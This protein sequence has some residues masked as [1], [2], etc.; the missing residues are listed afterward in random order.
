MPS[1]QS[2]PHHVL[3]EAY[4]R[5]V[6]LSSVLLELFASCYVSVYCGLI[7]HRCHTRQ[8]LRIVVLAGLAFCAI[9][10]IFL[11]YS[12]VTIN[13]LNKVVFAFTY[14]ALVESGRYGPMFLMNVN[15][16]VSIIN[17]LAII[18]P[19]IAI[20]AACST[21]APPADSRVQDLQY[22]TE[23]MQHLKEVLNAGSAL[24]V[25]GIL[26]MGAWL[27]WPAAL[28]SDKAMQEGVMN[29]ALAITLFWGATFTLVIVAT[30][31]PA[32]SR[33]STQASR[34]I[35]EGSEA[36][37]I[38]DPHKWLSDHGLVSSPM[39]QLPQIAAML[40]PL[41]AGPIGSVLSS[42]NLSG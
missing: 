7:I 27:R 24:L 4:A 28:V 26:H 25:A 2:A 5:Y 13:A 14:Q 34:V 35:K 8:R 19:A 18:A 33:L 9:G 36:G 38:E 6:W 12:S 11:L 3:D 30:Y 23:Q 22:L 16:V 40:A 42:L 20:L 41:L 31:G 17:G 15:G 29:L 39:K 1:V 32:A 37:K 10:I 21:L